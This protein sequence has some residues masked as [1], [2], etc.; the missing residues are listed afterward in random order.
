MLTITVDGTD[1]DVPSSAADTNWAADQIA[2]EQAL[3]AGVNTA[4][5]GALP[6]A[7]ASVRGAVSIAA[8]VFGGRKT[9]LLVPQ[10]MLFWSPTPIDDPDPTV[11]LAVGANGSSA[12]VRATTFEIT[13]LVGDVLMTATPTLDT[14][15]TQVLDGQEVTIFNRDDTN[16]FTFQDEGTLPDSAL[17]LSANTVSIKKGSSIRLRFFADT[18]LWHQVGLS[19]LV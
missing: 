17:R 12:T 1:Y 13:G 4:I 6:D 3:A 5:A 18:Q 8:Q 11:L 15:L 16:S 7:T 2:F 9:I 14:D 19:T 10:A